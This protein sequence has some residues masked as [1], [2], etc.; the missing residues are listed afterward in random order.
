LSLGAARGQPCWERD[1]R[2]WP[3][4]EASR[5]IESARLRW[6]VQRMGKGPML[7]LIHG[8][9]AATHSWRGL[10][11]LLARRFTV[12]APDLPGHGF[13]DPM[14]PRAPSLPGMA[15]ALLE[16]LHH[17]EIE[18]R[19][20]IGHSA[21]AAILARLCI[22][23]KIAPDLLV[24]LNGALLPFE[25]MAGHFLPPMAKL[26]FLNPLAPRLFAWSADRA[27]IGRLL[28]GTG[29]SIDRAGVDLY[30]RLMG[31]YGHVAGALGMMANW[32][33]ETL[34]R[35]LPKLRLP[36]ALIVARGD[37][38]VSPAA[39]EKIMARL[40]RAHVDYLGG[41]GHLAHEEK[42][43]MVCDQIFRLV[44]VRTFVDA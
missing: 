16:L 2:D 44:A 37:K 9:G 5:F 36:V 15:Q 18:P 35:D 41:V 22:D 20:V 28:R 14:S 32:D 12:V 26:L 6:H 43:E 30:A 33:L 11:P 4:R 10:A 3:N 17:L 24:S 42:P 23:Q 34:A 21:G 1:G 19:V 40:P 25:G 13:T 29:S 27:A 7:L 8:T 31:H 38:A 39:A